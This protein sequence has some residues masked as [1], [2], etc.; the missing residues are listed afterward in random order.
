ME[1]SY[2]DVKHNIYIPSYIII[3][4]TS[5]TA[6]IQTIEFIKLFYSYNDAFYKFKINY[7]DGKIEFVDIEQSKV[8]LFL[9]KYTTI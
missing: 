3:N 5:I 6:G 8:S 7:N 2:L 4:D 1:H 9:S